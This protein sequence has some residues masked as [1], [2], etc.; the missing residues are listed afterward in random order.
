MVVPRSIKVKGLL[1]LLVLWGMDCKTHVLSNTLARMIFGLS[2][3][4]L[5]PC[6]EFCLIC[7]CRVIWVECV[8]RVCTCVH[9]CGWSVLV[10]VSLVW[11]FLETLKSDFMHGA[12]IRHVHNAYVLLLC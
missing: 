10:C 1:L 6:L 11:L 8:C 5:R 3:S 2:P 12:L 7:V 9:V 4:L